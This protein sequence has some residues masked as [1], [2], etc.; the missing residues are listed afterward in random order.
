MPTTVVEKLGALHTENYADFTV[1]LP[2]GTRFVPGNFEELV[3]L[4][5]KNLENDLYL[6]QPNIARGI[7]GEAT[8]TIGYGFDLRTFGTWAE[9]R[10]VLVYGLGGEVNLTQL[11]RDGL[12]ILRDYRSG[13]WTDADI[14]GMAGNNTL[15][16]TW[17]D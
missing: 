1:T 12:Y 11:Q 5:L 14:Q 15:P 13:I 8:P 9:V 3:L 6:V 17:S 10:Q 2:N 16:A 7:H 4:N